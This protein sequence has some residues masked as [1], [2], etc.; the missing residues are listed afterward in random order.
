[1]ELHDPAVCSAC[2][3][4]QASLALNSFIRRKKT[5]LQFHTLKGRLNTH[6]GYGVSDLEDELV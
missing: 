2:E 6:L 3:Q 4:E 5:Q 1:M